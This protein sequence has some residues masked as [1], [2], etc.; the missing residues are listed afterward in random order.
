MSK[1]RFILC[2]LAEEYS[3]PLE[4][5]WTVEGLNCNKDK[6]SAFKLNSMS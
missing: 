1:K 2:M 6:E 4:N 5:I 3:I